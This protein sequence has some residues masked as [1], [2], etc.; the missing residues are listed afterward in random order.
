MIFFEFMNIIFLDIF[1]TL[2]IL[3]LLWPMYIIGG[4]IIFCSYKIIKHKKSKKT[5][6]YAVILAFLVLIVLFFA[7]LGY[8]LSFMGGSF[9]PC[10]TVFD[11]NYSNSDSFDKSVIKDALKSITFPKHLG[12]DEMSF[13]HIKIEEPYNMTGV[14]EFPA[15]HLISQQSD[16]VSDPIIKKLKDLDFISDVKIQ[17]KFCY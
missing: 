17:S 14:I 9:E 16:I 3:P 8:M 2:K 5:I 11:V 13:E 1:S 15:V 7:I 10:W 12:V 4:G 6:I